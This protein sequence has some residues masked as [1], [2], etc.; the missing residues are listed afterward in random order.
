MAQKADTLNADSIIGSN[1][2]LEASTI[3]TELMLPV[4]RTPSMA[5]FNRNYSVEYGYTRLSPPDYYVEGVDKSEFW[6][7][8]A[9]VQMAFGKTDKDFGVAL[10]YDGQQRS[11]EWKRHHPGLAVSYRL[12]LGQHAVIFAESITARL[13]YKR[14]TI[15]VAFGPAAAASGDWKQEGK[16]SFDHTSGLMYTWKGLLVDFSILNPNQMVNQNAETRRYWQFTN[17]Y[18]YHFNLK[19][20]FRVI[21]KIQIEHWGHHIE[22]IPNWYV[23]PG[24]ALEYRN[25]VFVSLS[26]PALKHY[27]FDLAIEF[28]RHLRL[29]FL[30]QGDL[31]KD[32]R[33][34][35][36]LPFIGGSLR[37]RFNPTKRTL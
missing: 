20:R 5:G 19:D 32:D 31:I 8:K 4:G 16:V 22:E 25:I 9:V 34:G 15:S 2:T 23:T 26:S 6:Q 27:R 28:I 7:Q 36:N 33:F 1:F 3:W 10:F 18:A 13:L 14:R 21:P 24:L 12:N 29:A 35:S 11:L 17:Y 37:Y 30:Y